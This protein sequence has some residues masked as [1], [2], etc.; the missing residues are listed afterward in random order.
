[1]KRL[2]GTFGIA[3]ILLMSSCLLHMVMAP[4][5]TISAS[6]KQLAL[7]LIWCVL[8][9]LRTV[10][11]VEPS[12]FTQVE[13]DRTHLLVSQLIL[14]NS[15]GL[16]SEELDKFYKYLL[17]NKITYTPMGICTLSR[18]LLATMLGSVATYLVI[19]IQ[20]SHFEKRPI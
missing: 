9:L 10:V 13:M 20:L 12:H 2:E 14:Q 4:N 5:N 17:L 16:M 11:I 8:H 18:S 1:M 19:L 3:L 15:D 7:H 6:C